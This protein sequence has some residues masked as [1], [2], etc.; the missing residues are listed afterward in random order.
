[1]CFR[2]GVDVD[3]L[4]WLVWF[5][6]FWRLVWLTPRGFWSCIAAIGTSYASELVLC[7]KEKLFRLWILGFLYK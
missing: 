1:M 4:V 5:G 7:T 6:W 2:I 3:K